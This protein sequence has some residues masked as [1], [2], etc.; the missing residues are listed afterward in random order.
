MTDSE[1]SA[2][3]IPEAQ[4]RP[5]RRTR[6]P[7]V[8]IIPLV[9]AVIGGSI[10]VR[11]IRDQGPE[12]SIS[13]Q[14]AD[15]LEAGKTKIRYRNVDV[16][17]IRTISLA[18]DH[19]SVLVRA[20]MVK[21]ARPLLVRD[22][23]FWVVRPRVAVGG[24]SGLGTLLSGS[25]VGM[26]I[27]HDKETSRTFRG[28]EI[29]PVVAGD[30]PGREYVLRG[31]TIGSVAVGSPVYFRHVEVGQVTRSQ[32]DGD[33]RGVTVGVFVQAPYDRF[34]TSDTRFWHASGVDVA[35]GSDGVRIETESLASLL[36]GGIAFETPPDS[37]E[38]APATG[39]RTFRLAA[40]R[41]AAMRSPNEHPMPY[42][43][44]FKGSLRG[45]SAGS[46]V[47]LNGIDVGEVSS[48]QIEYDPD[49]VA[50]RYPVEINIYPERIRALYRKGSVRP[51]TARTG[52][53]RFVEH[54]IEHGLRAQL[55]TA[56]LLTGQQ[57]VALDFFPRAAHTTSDP[58][59]T[60]MLMPTV[61]GGMDEL[62]DTLTSI[63]NKLNAVPLEKIGAHTDETLVA[64]QKTLET[65][66]Q[67]AQ[68]LQAEVAP[69]VADTLALARHALGEADGALSAQGPLQQ[70]LQQ[71]LR[72]L[73]RAAEALRSLADSLDRHPEALLRGK[74][75]DGS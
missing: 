53:Y 10:A 16:G 65:T 15:G 36:V 48:I 34:V 56:S 68:R 75:K 45:L 1:N 5:H 30:V 19:H 58:D 20:E 46:P 59:Q 3:A 13:F 37:T 72:Q 40:N 23:R 22:T 2:A 25:Y 31:D 41:G 6:V 74:P 52:V 35:L 66:N 42:L 57:Y 64:L 50:Y 55:R 7:L 39:D 27:G 63:A 4:P 14:T 71:A 32:L 26:D 54:L 60:P 70:N 8:W 67:L 24:V 29:P 47:E 9:T 44:Y 61:S 49:H 43:L 73:T 33:G 51:D 38:L 69:E 12:I 28:L 18:P 62:T 11:A 17:A 21:D